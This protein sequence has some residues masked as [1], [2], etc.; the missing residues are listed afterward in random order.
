VVSPGELD[1][2]LRLACSAKAME[3]KDLLSLVLPL[4]QEH[5]FKLYHLGL[6]VYK[7]AHSR[8]TFEAEDRSIFSKIYIDYLVI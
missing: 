4:W 7:R 2:Q 6:S 3:H 5:S 1:C 8:N